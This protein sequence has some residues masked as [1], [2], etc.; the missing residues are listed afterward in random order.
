MIDRHNRYH[1]DD[2]MLKNILGIMD[3]SMWVNMS[4]L[5]MIIVDTYFGIL[6]LYENNEQLWK[7]WKREAV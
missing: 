7:K 4:I 1:Q 3:W 2:L 6:W 5:G